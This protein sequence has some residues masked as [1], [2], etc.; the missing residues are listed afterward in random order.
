MEELKLQKL[1][2]DQSED[3]K[4]LQQQVQTKGSEVSEFKKKL[5]ELN[6][7]AK[8]EEETSEKFQSTIEAKLKIIMDNLHYCKFLFTFFMVPRLIF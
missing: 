6:F 5:L 2:S 1:L 8:V 7:N 3:L 4:A